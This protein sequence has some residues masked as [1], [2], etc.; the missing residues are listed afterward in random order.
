LQLT[1]KIFLKLAPKFP[2]KFAF[3]LYAVNEL[4]AAECFPLKIFY[5][6]EES[7]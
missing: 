1:G 3:R 4:F 6:F 7:S 5:S 2:L